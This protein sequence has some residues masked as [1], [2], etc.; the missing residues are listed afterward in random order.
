MIVVS[1]I[2]VVMLLDFISYNRFAKYTK[3]LFFVNG[4]V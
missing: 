3:N 2:C 4:Y 1:L